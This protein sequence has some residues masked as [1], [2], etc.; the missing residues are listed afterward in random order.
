MFHTRRHQLS[1]FGGVRVGCRVSV[2]PRRLG[3][4]RESPNGILAPAGID[5]KRPNTEEDVHGESAEI[6]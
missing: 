4:L 5:S 6:Y 1:P 2:T 3:H